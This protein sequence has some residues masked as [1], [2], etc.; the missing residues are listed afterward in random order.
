MV[1]ARDDACCHWLRNA[2]W[3]VIAADPELSKQFDPN[4]LETMKNG[5]APFARKNERI[6]KRVKIELHH[7][8][9]ISK[10]DDVYNVDNLN[11]LTPKRHIDIHKGN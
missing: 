4:S 7:K 3:K 6:G 2:F 9:E 1:L 10:G 11:A 5:R 8:V